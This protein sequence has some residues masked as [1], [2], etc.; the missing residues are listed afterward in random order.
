MARVSHRLVITV[1]RR[2]PCLHRLCTV[3]SVACVFHRRLMPSMVDRLLFAVVIGVVCRITVRR[4]LVMI[5]RRVRSM[6]MRCH[7][8]TMTLVG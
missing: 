5:R 1:V 2:F 4:L 3:K 6:A 7:L 8:L